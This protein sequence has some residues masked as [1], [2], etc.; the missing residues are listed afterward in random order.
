VDTDS[1]ETVLA[2][3]YDGS[4]E[5][6]GA[7]RGPRQL[8]IF[9]AG[10]VLRLRAGATGAGM[11]LL[12]GVPIGEPVVHYGPFVMNTAE[13]IEEAIRDYQSGRFAA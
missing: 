8:L 9:A 2:Y 11:L 5:V 13:E 12:R 4:L 3:V 6:E 7:D 1:Q 10:A